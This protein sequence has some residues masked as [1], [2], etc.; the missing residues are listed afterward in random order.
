MSW[1][2]IVTGMGSLQI[3]SMPGYGGQGKGASMKSNV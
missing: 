1:N 2:E 3:R